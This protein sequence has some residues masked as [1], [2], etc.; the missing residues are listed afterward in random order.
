[1][2]FITFDITGT[3]A[4]LM[5]NPHKMNKKPDSVGVKKL[6]TPQ[7]DA[8]SG[9]YRLP[10]GELY[11]PPAHFREC[12]VN[13]AK[14]RKVG[15]AFATMIVKSTVF[16][17]D[18]YEACPLVDPE[19]GVLL[20]EFEIDT[21]RAV[22]QSAGIMRSRARIP[23]WATQVTFEFDPDFLSSEHLLALLNIGGHSVGVGDYRPQKGG[24]FGRF[25]AS[26][27]EIR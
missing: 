4:L 13:A 22:V 20:T 24:P 21:R 12:T 17:A 16:E 5:N 7:E 15:K 8:E 14:G 27:A 11:L 1:M 25:E 2:A 6:P 9:S 18:G 26:I 19:T 3:Y 10:T 23:R